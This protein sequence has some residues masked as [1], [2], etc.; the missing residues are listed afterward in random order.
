MS[1]K[2]IIIQRQEALDQLLSGVNEAAGFIIQTMGPG[3]KLV[4][5]AS[6][7]DMKKFRLTK[8]GANASKLIKN[9]GGPIKSAGA[10]LI[11]EAC[12]EM[13]KNVGDGTT[14]VAAILNSLIRES[15]NLIRAGYNT[16]VIKKALEQIPNLLETEINKIK[17]SVNVEGE[18]I[19]KVAH[20][21]SNNERSIS[22]NLTDLIKKLG[23]DFVILVEESKTGKDEVILRDGFYF[24]KGP[25][26][27]YFFS[28]HEEQT[29]MKIELDDCFVLITGEKF[30]NI[31]PFAE[32]ISQ[33]AQTGKPMLIVG[34]DIEED[35]TAIFIT[36][37]I[38]LNLNYVCVK[39][40]LFGEKRQAFLEDLAIITGA[41]VIN[42][43][44]ISQEK[45]TADLLGKA[46]KIVIT[47]DI[48]TVIDGYGQHPEKEKRI[49]VVKHLIQESKSTYDKEKFQERLAR[50]QNGIGIFQV[51]GKTEIEITE[52]KERVEDAIHACRNAIQGGI[53]PGAG[54]EFLLTAHMVNEIKPSG[55]VENVL[56]ILIN[57]AFDVI[58]RTIVHNTDK[59][60]PDV[61]L[62]EIKQK[63]AQ[64]NIKYGFNGLTGAIEDLEKSGIIN[65]AKVSIEA[66]KIATSVCI[67]FIDLGAII[68]EEESENKNKTTPMMP[69]PYDM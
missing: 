10:S 47:R 54:L 59:A 65:P 33:I 23:R 31:R 56:K 58:T 9:L 19:R 25:T 21:A 49:E 28:K 27:P 46:K 15:Y 48:T 8:D 36:N 67:K 37:K 6:S 22:G 24:D 43:S 17:K 20:V 55:E 1:N 7:D 51:G 61:I 14:T 66:T 60:S 35:I 57:K 34:E 42:P 13:L 32:L 12:Q 39:A 18:E 29:R 16:N 68:Y 4:G 64:G 3:G 2:R 26:S 50:L 30:S 53:V 69:S 11:V 38:K 44:Q 52:R 41:T 63:I 40:P 45:I 5:F 62:S